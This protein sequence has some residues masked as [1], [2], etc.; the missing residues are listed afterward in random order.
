MKIN[1]TTDEEYAEYLIKSQLKGWKNK[2]D[3]QRPYRNNLKK[4][5]LGKTLDIGC[6]VGRNLSVLAEGSLGIDHNAFM[7]KYL[8]TKGLNALTTQEFKKGKIH[9]KRFDSILI[10]HVIEHLANGESKKFIREYSKY[11][12]K[13]GRILIIC[14]QSKGFSKDS[15][16]RVY[17]DFDSISKLIEST[18]FKVISRQSFPFP[19]F[20]GG[21]F[22]PNEFWVLGKKIS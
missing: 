9:K 20:M 6:G 7:I 3:V 1:S 15:T 19:V 14:P 18:G 21:S 12:K 2:L 11:L 22:G 8:K 17:Q 16:H 13:G 4:Y 10:A 5:N